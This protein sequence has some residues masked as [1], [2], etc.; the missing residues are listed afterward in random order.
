MGCGS[1]AGARGR[2]YL[3]DGSLSRKARRMPRYAWLAASLLAVACSSGDD[4]VPPGSTVSTDGP[5]AGGDLD[6]I[7]RYELTMERMDRIYAA[8][9]NIA[10]A[11]RDM[12]PAEREAMETTG[13]GSATL[14]EFARGIESNPKIRQAI[15]D[16]GMSPR[17]YATATMAMVSASMAASALHMRPTENQDSLAREMHANPANVRFL[18]ENEAELARKQEQLDT[19]L[20]EAGALD[21]DPAR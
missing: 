2:R 14:A 4:A 15:A 16:A 12:T 7:S 10:L 19:E 20:R 8:Q 11:I 17:E 9:R 1:I 3:C 18:R 21:D 5:A 6:D 13:G